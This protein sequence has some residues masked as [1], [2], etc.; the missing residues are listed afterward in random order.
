MVYH[1][2]VGDDNVGYNIG[3]VR[4]DTVS[5][6]AFESISDAD[7][8]NIFTTYANADGM[9]I[10]IRP[11]NGGNEQNAAKFAGH[12]IDQPTRYGY[13]KFRNGPGHGDFGPLEE[14]VLDPSSGTHFNGPVMCLIGERCMSSAEWFTLMMKAG[15]ATLIGARTRGSSGNPQL[16]SLSNGVNYKIPSWVA[17]TYDQEVIEDNGIA[18]DIAIP[19][20]QSFDENADHVMQVALDELWWVLP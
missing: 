14:K 10:D 11:N 2:F 18:P 12:F 16:F 1:G 15:G 20:D 19:S 3:Y 5:T 7:I 9:I 4:V 17:Y 13:Y 6:G 8:E